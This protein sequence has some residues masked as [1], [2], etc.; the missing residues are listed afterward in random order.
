[1]ATA[2]ILTIT[3]GQMYGTEYKI[4]ARKAVVGSADSNDVVLPDRT[5]E[6]RHIEIHQTLDRWFIVPLTL[7][8]RGISLNG[9]PVN[10]RSRVN[11]SD[12]ITLGTLTLQAS[13][14]EIAEQVAQSTARGMVPRLGEYFVRRGFMHTE[15]IDRI[16]QRQR[17]MRQ[18][19]HQAMFGEVA[20]ELGVVNRSQLDAALSDQRNDFNQRFLD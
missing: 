16:L 7:S 4:T 2:L 10:S 15:E 18:N 3:T 12:T 1:M 8:G 14:V 9:M 11:P 19:G 17:E 6:P 13:I 20:Y 5:V